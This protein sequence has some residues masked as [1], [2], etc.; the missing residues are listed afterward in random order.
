VIID[1]ALRHEGT[2]YHYAEPSDD[3]EADPELIFFA[4]DAVRSNGLRA[5]VGPTW[6]TDAPFRET[7]EAIE[8]AK[9]QGI[10]A[11]ENGSGRPLYLRQGQSCSR[12]VSC[13]C[14][15]RDGADRARL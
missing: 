10:L 6:T 3:G 1:R 12:A 5:I 11:V 9:R 8:A 2:S 13:P 15:Q 7:P 14:D 4:A